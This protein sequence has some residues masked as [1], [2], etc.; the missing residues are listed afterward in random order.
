METSSH[1]VDSPR[2]AKTPTES[3]V[4]P[5][6]PAEH[7]TEYTGRIK[8]GWE[9]IPSIVAFLV[10]YSVLFFFFRPN[11]MLALTTTSGGDMGAHHYP[12]QFLI[13]E[14]LPSFQVTGWTMGWYAGMPMLTFYLPLPF[15]LIALLNVVL[16]YTVAFKLATVT[17]IF[18][19]P[20]A[21]YIFGHLLRLRKPFPALAVLFALAFLFMES[22]SIYGANILS[23]LAGEFGYS[24]SFALA[25]IF[26][27]TLHRGLEIPRFGWFFALNAVLLAAIV[28]SHIVTVI[29]LCIVAPALLLV[30]RN[31]RAVL[32]LAAVFALAFF[33][34][35]FWGLPFIDKISWTAH[36]SWG[37]LEGIAE[38]LP[39]EI[40]L[41][42][43]LAVLGLAYALSQRQWNLVPLFWMA[44]AMVILF[45]TLPDGRLWNGRLLPF[46]YFSLHMWAAFAVAWMVRPFIVMLDDLLA[47]RERPARLLYVPIVSVVLAVI[48]A[49]GTTTA[50][51]WIKWNYEGYENKAAWPE[52]EQMM[53]FID[54]LEPQ[55]R[56]MWEHSPKLDKFGT[57]RMIELVPYWTQQW[58]MEGTLMES[59][60]TAPYHFINQAELS[61]EPSHAIIGVD[62]PPRNVADGISHLQFMNVPYLVTASPE[63]TAE[64]ESD[65]RAELL[66]TVDI[67]SVFRINDTSGY[68]EVMSNEPVKVRTE[69]WRSTIVPWYRNVSA[70][71]VP[72]VWDR[73]EQGLS[74]FSSIRPEEAAAPPARPIAAQGGVVREVVE[75]DRITFETTAIG[76]P[77]WVKV[78]YFPNWKAEGAEGPFVVSPSFMMV[79]PTQSEVTLHYART[80]SNILGQ[81]LTVLGWVIVV[82]VVALPVW[83]RRRASQTGEGGRA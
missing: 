77:H 41:V 68:V 35:A 58:G 7:E 56:V 70:L 19:L 71:E 81:L 36:M 9:L 24:I 83:R 63:V 29:V 1:S 28:L 78:S 32:Y 10:A 5:P 33:L 50:P 44:A 22:Y 46:F 60:F 54:S 73:G 80:W 4:A 38:V 64:A 52:H 31:V 23:T 61:A 34:S 75:N 45:F 37:Q 11:L 55:G 20:A 69:D 27:G 14:L 62:Y 79:I 67:V 12:A 47:V 40:R 13:D 17:G 72:V 43:A 2:A 16:P 76:Q 6:V 21:A 3:A 59:A 26:L 30:H 51:G 15:L 39:T 65:P 74:D 18:L 42:A 25:L 82:A 48:I 49:A 8:L 57:P 53:Q 66:T